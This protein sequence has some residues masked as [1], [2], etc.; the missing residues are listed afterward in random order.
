MKNNINFSDTLNPSGLDYALLREA[1]LHHLQHLAGR[2]WTDHN[3]H[4]PGITI[5]E[6]LCYTLT[7]LAYRTGHDLRDLLSVTGQSYLQDLYRPRAI[8]PTAPVSPAD[9]RRLLLDQ[10]GVRQAWVEPLREEAVRGF[11]AVRIQPAPGVD[12]ESLK[13]S[14]HRMLMQHRNL[15]EDFRTANITILQPQAVTINAQLEVEG[16]TDPTSLLARIYHRLYYFISPTLPFYS[17]REMLAKGYRMEEIM[18]GPALQR[19]YLDPQELDTFQ[20]RHY[21]RGSDLIHLFMDM[22]EVK[23][24]NT[25]LMKVSRADGAEQSD[26]WSVELDPAGFFP[27]LF[28]P[29]ESTPD[30]QLIQLY[31]GPIPLQIDK[32]RLQTELL[33]LLQTETQAARPPQELEPEVSPGRDRHIGHY[34]SIQHH[35]PLVYGIGPGGLPDSASPERKAQAKQLKA[36][37]LFFEQLLAD[38]LAQLANFPKLFDFQHLGAEAHTYFSQVPDSVPG[39]EELLTPKAEATESDQDRR[40]RLLDHLLARF[41]EKFA[42]YSLL[43]F[44][45]DS[46]QARADFLKQYQTIGYHRGAAFDYSKAGSPENISG[47]ERRLGHLLGLLPDKEGTAASRQKFFLLEHI[48]LLR[49]PGTFGEP[50]VSANFTNLAPEKKNAFC[51]LQLS[52]IFKDSFD[53]SQK[54]FI[55]R[56]VREETPAHLIA[57]VHWLEDDGDDSVFDAFSSQYQSWAD[58]LESSS[59]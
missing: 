40:A 18:N 57:H 20:P 21:L 44:G 38:Y 26:P 37:L 2:R 28:Q 17:L 16:V 5:L 13:D 50:V 22:P 36:Y 42:D 46:L 10:P 51:S 34:H 35:F 33:A 29:E 12:E 1:G 24:V 30:E 54:Q 23:L 6:Q 47:L 14:L 27:N 59:S 9:Y 8:L 25:L 56:T 58:S 39:M 19:G 32:E 55:E 3:T 4:D 15:C 53:D 48:L 52:F 49:D 31:S 11:Y 41:G 7:D 45:Q 43:S